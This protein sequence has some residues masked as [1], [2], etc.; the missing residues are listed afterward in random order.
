MPD[1]LVCSRCLPLCRCLLPAVV[2]SSRQSCLYGTLLPSLFFISC[3]GALGCFH[4]FV[5]LIISFSWSWGRGQMYPCW[6][7]IYHPLHTNSLSRFFPLCLKTDVNL[8]L[9]ALQCHIVGL[10]MAAILETANVAKLVR[11]VS[12]LCGMGVSVSWLCLVA[13]VSRLVV[14]WWKQVSFMFGLGAVLAIVFRCS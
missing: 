14:S 8:T 2:V 12:L 11:C 9:K 4:C 6:R 3:S 10:F 1:V 5:R 13:A 7:I